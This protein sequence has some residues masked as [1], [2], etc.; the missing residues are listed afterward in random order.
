MM[1]EE[2]S[3]KYYTKFSQQK[4]RILC[5]MLEQDMATK[6]W[7]VNPGL[8]IVLSGFGAFVAGVGVHDISKWTSF[9]S[10]IEKAMFEEAAA[11]KA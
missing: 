1:P 7:R 6:L 9:N 3:T 8:V 10:S 5:V 11:K 2:L 4:Y